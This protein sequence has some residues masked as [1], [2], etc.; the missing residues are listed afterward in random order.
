MKKKTLMCLQSV[1]FVPGGKGVSVKGKVTYSF[2]YAPPT[3]Q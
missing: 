2:S 3:Q 1:C